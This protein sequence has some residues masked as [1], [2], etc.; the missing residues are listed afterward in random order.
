MCV[1][2]ANTRKHIHTCSR[3]KNMWHNMFE[4]KKLFCREFPQKKTRK[5]WKIRKNPIYFPDFLKKNHFTKIIYCVL[6]WNICITINVNHISA[7]LVSETI[8]WHMLHT[9]LIMSNMIFH[10]LFFFVGNFSIYSK[11]PPTNVTPPK[12]NWKNIFAKIIKL[13]YFSI[14][15]QMNDTTCTSVSISI[16]V[17]HA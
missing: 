8:H 3:Q 5:I 11:I 15:F 4:K 14:F 17:W 7:L 1:S 12:K 16:N 13:F 10:I 6:F 9:A 2:L